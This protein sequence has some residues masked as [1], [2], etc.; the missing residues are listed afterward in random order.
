M[1]EVVPA[2]SE[3]HRNCETHRKHV[4]EQQ[5]YKLEVAIEAN[6]CQHSNSDTDCLLT[7]RTKGGGGF[8]GSPGYTGSQRKASGQCKETGLG[9]TCTLDCG[10]RQ[11]QQH[12]Q[13]PGQTRP[14]TGPAA[15]RAPGA[16]T[17]RQ[18]AC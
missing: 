6:Q 13:S 17:H 1:S 15:E 10:S 9:F 8:R 12:A 11:L 2:V 16:A 3:R 5:K 4:Q 14:E 7:M 18:D